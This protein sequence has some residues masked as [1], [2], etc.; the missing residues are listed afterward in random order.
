MGLLL[1][2][3]HRLLNEL[4]RDVREPLSPCSS[5]PAHVLLNVMHSA[6]AILL[7]LLVAALAA[8]S[9][10]CFA[11]TADKAMQCC[12]S[13]SCPQHHHHNS[14]DCCQSMPSVHAPFTLPHSVD[15]ASHPLVPLALLPTI[16]TA[17][18]LESIAS[19][20]LALAADCHAPPGSQSPS[21]PLRI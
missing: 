19:V 8:Y 6:R 11:A 4:V 16:T 18:C 20:R 15:T 12:D 2:A 7:A 13:M 5:A 21:L 1:S 17:R 10:D 3:P 14:E 9:L